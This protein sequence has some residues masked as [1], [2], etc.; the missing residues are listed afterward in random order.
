MSMQRVAS[1]GPDD[2][3]GA[4]FAQVDT[5]VGYYQRVLRFGWHAILGGLVLGLLVGTAVWATLPR[6]YSAS[7]S[8]LV[9]TTGV[10]ETAAVG[11]RT[12]AGDV[13]LDTEAQI[14]TSADVIGRVLESTGETFQAR[15]IADQVSV[16][17][18]PNTTV[19]DITV[20]ASTP[21]RARDG[22]SAFADSYLANRAAVAQA[23]LQQQRDAYQIQIDATQASYDALGNG[24]GSRNSAARIRLNA[25]IADLSA[26]QSAS[27]SVVVSPGR[28]IN[29]ADL[30]TAPASPDLLQTVASIAAL[31]LLC[32]LIISLYSQRARPKLRDASD[33]R[34]ELDLPL[35]ADV[36]TSRT[37]RPRP[38][39]DAHSL[40]A[41]AFSQLQRNLERRQ[42]DRVIL[43]AT[44]S[45]STAVL[46]GFNLA[47]QY[48]RVGT[49]V[50]LV[51][52]DAGTRTGSKK[53]GR[54]AASGD[55]RPIVDE[56]RTSAQ[57]T[58]AVSEIRASVTVIDMVGSLDRMEEL[59]TDF[60]G[61]TII[62]ILESSVLLQFVAA[63]GDL[64]VIVVR[65]TRD[66]APAVRIRRQL[67]E[68]CDVTVT[69]VVLHPAYKGEIPMMSDSD[70]RPTTPG[71]GS[72]TPQRADA[73]AAD[74]MTVA[75]T[76]TTTATSVGRTS[77]PS[78]ERRASQ[79]RRAGSLPQT[80]PVLSLPSL[81]RRS[82]FVV[83][84]QPHLA[85]D[86]G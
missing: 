61:I 16:R 55:T 86:D 18:P 13:N 30:P 65:R 25:Q 54:P 79:Q 3:N 59:D 29:A 81:S 2:R 23:S 31:G 60:D 85:Q 19:L 21:S 77:N 32:G 38:I 40:Q 33:V 27:A 75:R 39:P 15:T 50:R 83:R 42:A 14:V 1:P 51:L 22:A 26:A 9:T 57:P 76:S 47:W 34:R 24:Q 46:V 68:A 6:T 64:A 8:V 44:S 45:D 5:D 37:D 74:S 17:V 11:S 52:E 70:L 10:Q 28:V 63:P 36:R 49:A 48:A 71:A 41:A 82:R 67:I 78:L 84:E 12:S 58:R 20:E 4:I 43:A 80:R 53:A 56:A 73:A 35:L 7:A 66:R 62:C 69:G 72:A